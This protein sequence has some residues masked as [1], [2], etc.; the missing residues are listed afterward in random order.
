MLP[1]PFMLPEPLMPP[2]PFIL[3]LPFMLLWSFMP[4]ESEP[5]FSQAANEQAATANIT[6]PTVRTIEVMEVSRQKQT[7]PPSRVGRDLSEQAIWLSTVGTTCIG[8]AAT[9]CPVGAY[10]PMRF[11]RC[12]RDAISSNVPI[13]RNRVPCSP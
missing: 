4:P 3:P 7:R 1:E 8:P 9:Q 11:S 2:L 10:D 6:I 5:M 12:N 13:R